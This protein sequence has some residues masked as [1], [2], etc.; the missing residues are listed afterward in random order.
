MAYDNNMQ[1]QS[2]S[3][4]K[5]AEESKHSINKSDFGKNTE[6]A[7]GCLGDTKLYDNEDKSCYNIV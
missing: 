6:V 7:Y 2:E 1:D 5:S 4:I 3:K